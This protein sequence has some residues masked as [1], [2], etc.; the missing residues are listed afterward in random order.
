MNDCWK[1]SNRAFCLVIFLIVYIKFM[2]FQPFQSFMH[3][4]KKKQL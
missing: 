3:L 2:C 1:D 4:Y